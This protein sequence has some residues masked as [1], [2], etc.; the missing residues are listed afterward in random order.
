MER[1][2]E[3]REV[4]L[5]ILGAGVLEHLE[6][7]AG[8]F[9]GCGEVHVGVVAAVDGCG[10]GHFSFEVGYVLHGL[11]QEGYDVAAFYG[12]GEEEVIA[13][14]ASHWPPVDDAAAPYGMIAQEGGCEV[15]HGVE[16]GGGEGGFTVGK[17]HADVEG[18][19]Y[20]SGGGD[21][22][23]R[24]VYA[25]VEA[26]VVNHKTGYLFHIANLAKIMI[27]SYIHFGL[28]MALVA[29]AIGVSEGID[30]WRKQL[31]GAHRCYV[32]DR[33]REE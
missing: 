30:P 13:C 24:H 27:L 29:R 14:A 1:G 2:G 22:A 9:A 6:V 21:I 7:A 10:S 15:L 26:L 12:A 8:G 32:G 4:L 20:I 16:G 25:P 11:A 31:R 19:D 33:E 28:G 5:G 23:A 17:C 18:G 3:R